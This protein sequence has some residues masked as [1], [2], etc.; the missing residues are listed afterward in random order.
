MR[1]WDEVFGLPSDGSKSKVHWFSIG[2]WDRE[3]ISS[4]RVMGR[5]KAPAN[6]PLVDQEH[7]SVILAAAAKDR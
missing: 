3:Y 2:H 4:V 1:W 6:I 5:S 7:I